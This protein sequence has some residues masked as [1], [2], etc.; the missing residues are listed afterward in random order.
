MG[1]EGEGEEEEGP[2]SPL[3]LALHEFFYIDL[4]MHVICL[5]LILH[6]HLLISCYLTR[7]RVQPVLLTEPPP[8]TLS[9]LVRKFPLKPFD[10]TLSDSCG[11]RA[12]S[13]LVFID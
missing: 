3:T 6:L 10:L 8:Q 5:A 4:L 2:S 12:V 7:Y 9:L 13:L 11:A 1:E